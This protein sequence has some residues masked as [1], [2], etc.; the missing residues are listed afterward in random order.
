MLLFYQSVLVTRLKVWKSKE[1][2]EYTYL[3]AQ[4]PF[5]VNIVLRDSTILSIYKEINFLY[6]VFY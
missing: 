5:R 6:Y 3:Y 2:C 4:W 1:Y